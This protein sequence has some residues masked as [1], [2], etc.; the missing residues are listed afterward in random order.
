[1]NKINIGAGLKWKGK[2]WHT[3]DN[4]P[5]KYNKNQFYGKCWNSNL[6]SNYYNIVFSSHT[7]EH[8]PQFRI[9][10]T[11]SE[12]N[13]I[14]KING[15]IRLLVPNLKL[16]A[17]AYI[18]NNK[19]FFKIS[20][21]YNE[22]LGIGGSFMRLL[23]S[24]GGQTV[25]VSRE[26]DEIIGG[27][28]HLFCYDFIILKSILEK[29]GFG[30]IR[31]CKPGKSTINE[32]REMQYVNCDG[33]KYSINHKFIRS[34]EFLKSNF[35][36]GGFDKDWSNQLIV[37]AKKIK[38]VKYDKNI[39][40]IDLKQNLNEGP[41]DIVKLKVYKTI[42]ILIDFIYVILKTLK[43]NKLVKFLIR[44]KKIFKIH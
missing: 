36:F 34:R 24:P 5:G 6:K 14:M 43:I 11:I 25:A 44:K 20:K 3:L 39:E 17:K 22:D 35:F 19:S 2:N 4:A 37:E 42:S 21:H 33:K 13:R 16:A 31:E 8:I 30:K 15:T 10:K 26:L 29:W 27:Y 12:F 38:N 1:M 18:T 28:A 23:I 40:F 9:E 7:L 32:L 41:L